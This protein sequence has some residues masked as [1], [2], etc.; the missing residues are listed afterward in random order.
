MIIKYLTAA[1]QYLSRGKWKN[2]QTAACN[3]TYFQCPV[4]ATVMLERHPVKAE[5]LFYDF[6]IKCLIATAC[7]IRGDWW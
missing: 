1:S 6:I 2:V 5:N 3:S 7:S 4:S